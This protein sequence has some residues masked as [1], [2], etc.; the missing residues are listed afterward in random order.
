VNAAEQAAADRLAAE[1][2]DELPRIVA[3]VRAQLDDCDSREEALGRL[4]VALLHNDLRG[5]APLAAAAVLELA[6]RKDYP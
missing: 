1:A 2:R 5:V 4:T 6:Y 3:D